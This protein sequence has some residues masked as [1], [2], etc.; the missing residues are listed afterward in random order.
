M[1]FSHK[2]ENMFLHCASNQFPG[3][4][5]GPPQQIDKEL[6]C[7]FICLPC[8]LGISLVSARAL[9]LRS[10]SP[11]K[12]SLP[13]FFRTPCT[14]MKSWV[15]PH[16]CLYPQACGGKEARSRGLAGLAQDSETDAVSRNK[17]V[18]SRTP[19]GLLWP[20]C[21]CTGMSTHTYVC[22]YSTHTC[23]NTHMHTQTTHSKL[24][25]S[26]IKYVLSNAFSGDSGV[27]WAS[28]TLFNT[29]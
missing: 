19:D 3:Y 20:P 2:K 15:W 5:I 12:E 1:V 23:S 8:S 21:I 10:W 27:T 11:S 17:T 18:L 4:R 22:T 28:Q 26:G 25:D 16:P 9:L 7:P 24:T 29:N 13:V 6:A 14:H